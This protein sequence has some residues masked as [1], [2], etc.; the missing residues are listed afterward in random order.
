[1]RS[2]LML[3]LLLA[4]NATGA[5]TVTPSALT[6]EQ[7]FEAR[8]YPEA[9]AA[10]EV[11]LAK[12]KN[13]AAAMYYMGR[14]AIVQNRSGEAVDWLEQAIA[15]DDANALYHF[16]LGS[17]LGTEAQR[18][19]KLRQPFLAR[20]V[21]N[22]FE[23]AVQLDP[24]TI[25]ARLG[26]VDFYSV[27]PGIMGGSMDKAK[28]QA[29]ALAKL[30]DLYG[31]LALARIAER[32]KDTTGAEREYKAAIVASPDSLT[33]YYSLGGFYRR[34]A[35]WDDAFATYD[36]AAKRSPELALPRA[37]YGI[38]AAQSGMNME[39]GESELKF[40]LAN[41]PPDASP[42]T[43]SA[44]HQRLGQLYERTGRRELATGEYTEALRVNARN[45]D[46]KKALDALK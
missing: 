28:E 8:R 21:K 33:P 34:I 40:Y 13:D 11:R 2:A 7:L 36:A 30:S 45:Q 14:I 46:A 37:L 39:R 3:L 32:V 31:H 17:A 44:V 35:R 23:R 25:E 5:Q 20:R 10:F 15:R 1:M 24:A 42:I 43:I 16:W 41:V 18:A 22:E 4:G 27:A 9:R 38:T 19:S 6:A 26:L 29:A 12:E